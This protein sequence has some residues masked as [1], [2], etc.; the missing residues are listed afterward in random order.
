MAS[1]WRLPCTTRSTSIT[2]L[3]LCTPTVKR[4][5]RNKFKLLDLYKQN[6]CLWME[7]HKDFLNF[8]LK[9]E[10]WDQVAQEMCCHEKSI[11]KPDKWRHLVIKWRY[12]VH[13]EELHKQKAIHFD[14]LDELPRRLRYSDRI[15]F[16]INHTFDRK[17]T[18][19][20]GPRALTPDSLTTA[21]Q[22]GLAAKS[23]RL[24]RCKS[25][26]QT[27]FGQKLRTMEKIRNKRRS[28][29]SLSPEALHRLM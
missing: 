20:V 21:H 5:W 8:E 22:V 24:V 9:D 29:M 15:Q 16:L 25:K 2:N 26:L 3:T 19:Q 10:L 11:P 28:T 18:V 12:N 17:K 13:L 1:D 27:P 4:K 6:E 7:N 14:T 23:M